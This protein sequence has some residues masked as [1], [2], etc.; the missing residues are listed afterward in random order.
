MNLKYGSYHITRGRPNPG[1]DFMIPAEGPL[2]HFNSTAKLPDELVVPLV[3]SAKEVEGQEWGREV[4]GGPRDTIYIDR[5]GSEG[6]S[7]GVNNQLDP[8]T[9]CRFV[10]YPHYYLQ[11]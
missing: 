5:R 2:D 10:D 6:S 4:T 9:S 3:K 1:T 8:Q 7:C 11:S